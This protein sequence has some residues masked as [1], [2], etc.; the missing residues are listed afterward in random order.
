ML[1]CLRGRNISLLGLHIQD[2]LECVE[3]LGGDVTEGRSHVGV[4]RLPCGLILEALRHL[5]YI[6]RL[7]IAICVYVP[8]RVSSDSIAIMI[9]WDRVRVQ[10]HVVVGVGYIGSSVIIVVVIFSVRSSVIIVVRVQVVW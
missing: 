8:V 10:V 4:H 5:L 9:S 3:R 1:V 6:I 7:T 2:P